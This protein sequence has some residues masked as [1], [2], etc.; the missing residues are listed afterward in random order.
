MIHR[1]ACILSLPLLLLTIVAHA[2]PQPPLG[3]PTLRHG[4]G[5]FDYRTATAEQKRLVEGAHFFP[6]VEYLR[7]GT[8]HP[9]R[10]YIVVPG[11]EIDYTLRAFPNHPRALHAMSRWSIQEKAD[12]PPG[13]KALVECY[14]QSA[15]NFRPDDSM[16]RVLYGIHLTD[17]GRIKD[18]LNQL[19]IAKELGSNSPSM[20]YNLGL[21]YFEIKHYPDA[22][23]A[24]H[25]AY[26][27]GASLPGLRNLL[28]RAGAWADPIAPMPN[29]AEANNNSLIPTPINT[30]D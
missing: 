13:A 7:K 23:K 27:L 10:G 28:E 17:K 25:K 26:D 18:A 24:A 11:G 16:V 15:I 21:A 4:Y 8:P 22:L 5:P 6:N 14:F 3:C 29:E 20:Y 30:P 9:N 1:L 19:N 12:P 2:E